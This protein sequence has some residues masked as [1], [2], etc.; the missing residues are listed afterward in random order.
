MPLLSD[1]IAIR[2]ILNREPAWAAYALGDL[3]PGL[4]DL[5][6][7]HVSDDPDPALLL[8]YRGFDPPIAI[9]MGDPHRLRELFRELAPTRIWLNLKREALAAIEGV[10]RPVETMTVERMV[11]RPG[12]FHVTTDEEVEPVGERDF[13]AINKL[14]ETGY[15][16]QDGPTHFHPSMLRQGTFRGL[17]ENGDLISVAGTHL[18][19][20]EFGVCAIGNVYTRADRRGRGLAARVTSVVVADS[21]R[22]GVGTIVLNV[23]T[24]NR[25]A[26]RVYERLGF[27]RYCDY[28]EGDA[29]RD[30]TD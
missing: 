5:C 22:A 8:L 23:G 13:E 30:F 28:L 11:L 3:A 7:W 24:E 26:R 1:P 25:T 10:Y 18:Y 4:A 6:E 12:A 20:P 16:R 9:A 29:V 15:R 19:A 21:L 17:W 2:A 27:E 14:Y